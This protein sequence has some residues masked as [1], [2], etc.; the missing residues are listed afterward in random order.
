MNVSLM[1]KNEIRIKSGITISV[2]L[3]VK[4]QK[5]IKCAIKVLFGI[6]ICVMGKNGKYLESII[7]NP[8]ITCDEIIDT[9]KT[10]PTKSVSI[11]TVPAKSTSINFYISLTIL[12]ITKALLIG[13]S[14][15]QAKKNNIYC[16]MRP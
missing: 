10:F 14:I 15:W 3:S 11:K 16:Q 13:V 5:K 9:A 2:C 4:I 1:V 12:L 7:D 6:L 8:V